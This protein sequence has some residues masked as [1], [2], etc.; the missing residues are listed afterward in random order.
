YSD[1]VGVTCVSF[2]PKPLR[3]QWYRSTSSERIVKRGKFVPIENFLGPRMIRVLRTGSSPALPDFVAC[4]LK[5]LFVICILP[6]NEIFNDL[7]K[8][9]A[10]FILSLFSSENVRMRRRI[11]HH[12]RKDHR[13]RRR[14]RPPCPPQMQRRRMPM[15]NRLFPRRRL[16]NGLQGQGNFDEFLL[17]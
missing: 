16:V 14:Q 12:L 4:P 8:P 10:L 6:L 2:K 7:E 3:L 9:L 5:N 17:S 13:S 15:P 1:W 11:V